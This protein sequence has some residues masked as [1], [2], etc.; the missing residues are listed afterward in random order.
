M[1]IRHRQRSASML[2]CVIGL[3]FVI[4]ALAKLTSLGNAPPDDLLKAVIGPSPSARV[5]VCA[6]EFFLGL[7]IIIGVAPRLSA[8]AT[9]IVCSSFLGVLGAEVVKAQPKPCGCFGLALPMSSPEQTRAGLIRSIGLN[10]AMM[11]AAGLA[12]RFSLSARQ[13][14]SPG[15]FDVTRTSTTSSVLA[16]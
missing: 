2:R 15:D 16:G 13:N 12:L 6:A 10:V 5:V 9:L 8:L 11:V 1:N 4:A 14:A 3:V 7:W